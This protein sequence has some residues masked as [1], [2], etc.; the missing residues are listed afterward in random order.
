MASKVVYEIPKKSTICLMLSQF[1]RVAMSISS[2]LGI[3]AIHAN[4]LL[5]LLFQMIQ[6]YFVTAVKMPHIEPVVLIKHV[7]VNFYKNTGRWLD[8]TTSA[9]I[10][11]IYCKIN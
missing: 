6:T 2:L 4:V 3:N 8:S 10:C 7:V 5:N 1:E 9:I 11:H